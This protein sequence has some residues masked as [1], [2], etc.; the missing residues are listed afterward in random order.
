MGLERI[1]DC[2]CQQATRAER[3]HDGGAL[4]RLGVR[5]FLGLQTVFAYP[6]CLMECVFCT[7]MALGVSVSRIPDLLFRLRTKIVVTL[8]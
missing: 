4:G 7:N 2:V 1:R 8:V 6:P 3:V 5:R